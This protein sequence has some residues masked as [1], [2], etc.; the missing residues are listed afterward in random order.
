MQSMGPLSQCCLFSPMDHVHP[1]HTKGCVTFCFGKRH[2]YFGL[3]PIVNSFNCSTILSI[4]QP[5]NITTGYYLRNR[6]SLAIVL[7]ESRPSLLR[8]GLEVALV[9]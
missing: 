3:W 4:V 1:Y 8:V 9:G 6:S 5:L 2:S 7:L